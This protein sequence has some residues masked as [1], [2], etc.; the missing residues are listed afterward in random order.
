MSLTISSATTLPRR[1]LYG[2]TSQILTAIRS[3]V[4]TSADLAAQF[5]VT[6][7]RMSVDLNRMADRLLIVRERALQQGRQGPPMIKWKMAEGL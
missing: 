1:R 5:G 7:S 4:N 6:R 3:G 2:R